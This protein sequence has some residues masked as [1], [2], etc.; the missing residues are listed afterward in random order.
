MGW[1][2]RL[3][4]A[5]PREDLSGIH[6]DTT[7]SFWELD[8]QTDFP[9]LLRALSD[10][11]PDGCI[12]YFEGG[13]PDKGLLEFFNTRGIPE[14]S[15]VAV[16]TI[17]PKPSCFHVPATRQNLFELAALAE[18]RAEP[19]VAVHFHV[20]RDAEVLLEWYDVFYQ[21]MC[22][23]AEFPEHVVRALGDVLSMTLKN[24]TATA[25]RPHQR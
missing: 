12:L 14:Q 4:G 23:S 16:G 8:G 17:W 19:E 20:Y 15:H 9:R 13:S 25:D 7:Q 24:S 22:L 21:P 18:S 3:F 11:L 5:T 1:L 10:F 2:A 6:L